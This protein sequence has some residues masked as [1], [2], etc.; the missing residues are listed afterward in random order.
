MEWQPI[1]S[2][3][4]DGTVLRLKREHDGHVVKE[5]AGVWGPRAANAPL[6]HPTGPDP[7]GRMTAADLRLEEASR[8]AYADEPAWLT[9]DRLYSFPT[10]THWMPL[11]DPP[12]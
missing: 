12:T 2:A 8:V 4:K 1:D 9:E 11:P 7:L 5:G 6:R 3:P 10:P